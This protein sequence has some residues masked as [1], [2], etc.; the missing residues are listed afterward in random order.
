MPEEV[1]VFVVCDS[2]PD[3]VWPFILPDEVDVFVVC[4]SHADHALC[5]GT[6]SL[7]LALEL[8][9]CFQSVSVHCVQE[10][11]TDEA[12]DIGSF[13]ADDFIDEPGVEDVLLSGHCAHA[14]GS[15]A[16]EAVRYQTGGAITLRDNL[17][18]DTIVS[19]LDLGCNSSGQ[20]G[21][22]VYPRGSMHVGFERM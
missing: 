18:A 3:H 22:S 9:L 10:A 6:I 4:E 20:C 17:F 11:S 5:G 1:N 15:L 12:V 8:E 21:E 16:I 2:D 14:C 7:G 19:S 13:L